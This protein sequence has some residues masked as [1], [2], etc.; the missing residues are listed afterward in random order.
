MDIV[1]FCLSLLAYSYFGYLTQESPVFSYINNLSPI[2][3]LKATHIAPGFPGL[4]S[5]PL[6]FT[7]PRVNPYSEKSFLKRSEIT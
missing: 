1:D 3:T 4:S 2:K 7:S 5:P 6:V